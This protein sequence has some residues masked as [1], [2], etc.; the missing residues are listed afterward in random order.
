[1][2]PYFETKNGKLYN[3][4]CLEMLRQMPENSV[5]LIVTSPPYNMRTRIRDGKYT[6]R[7][8]SDHFSKK[9]AEFDDA[10]S[11]DDF[12]S[13]HCSVMD[14][15][16]KVSKVICY[17]IQLVTGS[18]DAFFRIIGKYHA[19]IKDIIVWDKGWGQPAMAE[20]VLNSCY[21]LIL[22]IESEGTAGR[23]IKNAVFDRGEMQN[24][25]RFSGKSKPVKG[26]SAVFP[27]DIPLKLIKAFSNKNAIIFD[28]FMGSGTTAVAAQLS[29][30]D[31]LGSEISQ[32]YCDIAAKR[33]KEASKQFGLFEGKR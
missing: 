28:P 24:I 11:I 13:F 16:L 19:F 31:W 18:K 7:E 29:G 30:R 25:L 22:V 20:G 1:M 26:H 4:C 3:I 6:T 33:I 21:E 10:L 27:E 5:D 17:N 23:Q 12:F 32:V 15:M 8:K 14:E 2:K 9:Y